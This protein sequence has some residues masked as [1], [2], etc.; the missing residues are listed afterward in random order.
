MVQ[1]W[2]YSLTSISFVLSFSIGSQR[3]ILEVNF[4]PSG[5][6][7]QSPKLGFSYA[8]FHCASR[9]STELKA[10]LDELVGKPHDAPSSGVLEEFPVF[11]EVGASSRM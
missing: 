9:V 1:H 2:L 7:H 5:D 4:G 8:E 3:H 10:D 6:L 11:P